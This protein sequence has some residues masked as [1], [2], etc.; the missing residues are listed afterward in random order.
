MSPLIAGSF[1]LQVSGRQGSKGLG[2]NVPPPLTEQ[3]SGSGDEQ[4]AGFLSCSLLC[5]VHCL[6][7]LSERCLQQFLALHPAMSVSRGRLEMDFPGAFP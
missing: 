2:D 7:H 6:L 4:R 3:A 5:C 1:E